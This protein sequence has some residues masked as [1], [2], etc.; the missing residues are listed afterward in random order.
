MSGERIIAFAHIPKTAGMTV[1]LLL[2]RHFGVRHL[3]LPKGFIYTEALL[4]RDLRLNPLVRSLAGH[5]LRPFVDFGALENRLVW[6]TFLRDPVQRFVSHYQHAVEKEGVERPFDVWLREPANGNWHVRMLAGGEDLERAKEVL[7]QKVTCV[8]LMERF[9]ESLLLIR[10]SLCLPEL[11]LSYGAPRNTARRSDLRE[12]I[13]EECDRHRAEVMERNALD[14]AL[15]EYATD[16][17]YTAQ[18]E[19]YG[20]QRLDDDMEPAFSEDVSAVSSAFRYW[21]SAVFRRVFFLPITKVLGR[22]SGLA[23]DGTPLS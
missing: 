14:C 7:S 2:R 17:L 6:Y 16:V 10:D 9:N 15:Y 11:K 23:L 3:D 5:S 19:R 1:Q 18:V 8:G 12:R 22:R 21:Q 4:S 13:R 20:R